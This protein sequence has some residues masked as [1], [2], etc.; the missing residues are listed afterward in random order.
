MMRK[1]LD[2]QVDYLK[3]KENRAFETSGLEYQV[4]LAFILNLDI[5]DLKRKSDGNESI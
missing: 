3:K 1:R 2:F 4:M 5:H